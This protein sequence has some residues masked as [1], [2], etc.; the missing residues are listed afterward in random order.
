M[1]FCTPYDVWGVGKVTSVT[2]AGM[3]TA[4]SGPNTATELENTTRVGAAPFC[5]RERNASSK[6]RVLSRL[7]RKPKSKSASHSPDTADAKWNTPST[8]SCAK[9]WHCSSKGPVR[10]STRASLAKSAGAGNWSVKMSLVMLCPLICPRANKVRA[11][12]APMNP[13]PPVINKRMAITFYQ[14]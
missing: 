12:R 8:A 11:N 7:E 13:A 5:V 10:T 2:M 1:C 14:K 9:A 6:A 4:S 3:G